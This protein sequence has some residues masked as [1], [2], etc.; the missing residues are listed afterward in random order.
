MESRLHPH[1]FPNMAAGGFCR[2]VGWLVLLA[3]AASVGIGVAHF[4]LA[5]SPVLLGLLG[6]SVL[7][8]LFGIA[9]FRG[10]PINPGWFLGVSLLLV[11]PSF[12]LSPL[13][14]GFRNTLYTILLVAAPYFVVTIVRTPAAMRLLART[15]EF[16]AWVAFVAYAGL[17]LL[18]TTN[19]SYGA[20]KLLT[21]MLQ[22]LIPG[23]VVLLVFYSRRSIS[24]VPLLYLGCIFLAS[25]LLYGTTVQGRETLGNFNT[26]WVSRAALIVVTSAIWIDTHRRHRAV[27]MV[28]IALGL[29]VAYASQSRGPLVAFLIATICASAVVFHSGS[30]TLRRR[31][32]WVAGLLGVALLLALYLWVG[33]SGTVTPITPSNRL[34]TLADA[35][36]L[37]HDP[38]V[39]VRRTS[40]G[41]A[42][43]Q[44][45][46]N[47]ILGNGLGSF[48]PNGVREYP[49]NAALEIA[50]ELGLIGL[51]LWVATFV[52]VVRRAWRYP[53]L[54]ALFVQT[55]L[56]AQFSG[57]LGFNYE[58]VLMT[59]IVGGI[60]TL[61]DL[62]P[63]SRSHSE[64]VLSVDPPAA[65]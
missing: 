27:R 24:L 50:A 19:R 28:A 53:V 4:S 39:E 17:S 33:S 7:V 6:G 55:F 51:L 40:Q 1:S 46:A 56:Y 21:F 22:A 63:P 23:A 5:G 43:G 31:A 47:P 57:D 60:I 52:R 11:F 41:R 9:I 15:W 26:I 18:W 29:V 62:T 45:L 13:H 8:F 12:L 48:A 54:F 25:V 42:I 34:A 64:L 37:A 44:F 16:R 65:T 2:F 3:L 35:S 49:H 36:Q 20:E 10:E 59:F 38:T 30:P 32:G 14:L 58:Y 61:R